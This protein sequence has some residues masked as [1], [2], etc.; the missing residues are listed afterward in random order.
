[1]WTSNSQKEISNGLKNP[2]EKILSAGFFYPPKK[3]LLFL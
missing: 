1:M 2:T 3:S